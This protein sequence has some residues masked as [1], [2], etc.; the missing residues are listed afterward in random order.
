[1]AEITLDN[2]IE[3]TNANSKGI[4]PKSDITGFNWSKIPVIL[5]EMGYRTNPEEDILC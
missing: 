1:M 5:V 2:L 4:V 3:N